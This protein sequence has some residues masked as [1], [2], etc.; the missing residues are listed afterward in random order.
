MQGDEL[1]IVHFDEY[2]PK[3]KHYSK[4]GSE[5]PCRECLDNPVNAWSH[6][7]V[8]FDKGGDQNGRKI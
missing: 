3:C 4:S 1:K 2:C 8:R 7:P 5:D 6:K